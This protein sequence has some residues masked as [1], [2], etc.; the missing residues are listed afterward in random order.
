[1]RPYSDAPMSPERD[2]FVGLIP[3]GNRRWGRQ[4]FGVKDLSPEQTLIAYQRGAQAVRSVAEYARDNSIAVFAAWAGSQA[5]LTERS[6][7][8]IDVLRVVVGEFLTDLRDDWMDRPENRSVRFVHLGFRGRI[9]KL[10]PEILDGIDAVTEHTRKRTGMIMALCFDYDGKEERRRATEHWDV[11][12]PLRK[13][14]EDCLDLPMRTG[15][16]FRAC[17]LIIRTG[18]DPAYHARTNEFLIGY[19]H[20]TRVDPDPTLLP[21]YTSAQFKNSLRKYRAEPQRRGK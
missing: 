8:E 2:L 20:E 1:M 9:M 17:D 6:K 16:P 4:E 14:V 3:D 13:T 18:H 5:N 21:D 15:L 12:R 10:M 11:L 19:H 7:M